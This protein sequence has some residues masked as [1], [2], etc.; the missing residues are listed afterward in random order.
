MKSSSFA[1]PW[2]KNS[3][4]CENSRCVDVKIAID[5]STIAGTSAK[6][7]ILCEIGELREVNGP[8][9]RDIGRVL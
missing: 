3:R 4:Q 1:F 2:V 8:R 7:L 6:K 9:L 5:L